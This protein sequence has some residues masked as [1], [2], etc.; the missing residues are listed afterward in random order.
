MHDGRYAVQC[1]EGSFPIGLFGLVKPSQLWGGLAN[2]S[3]VKSFHLL[4]CVR[5][6]FIRVVEFIAARGRR[7]ASP[8][9]ATL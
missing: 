6:Q 8:L 1:V 2:P 5:F 4:A 7:L 3:G 9:F